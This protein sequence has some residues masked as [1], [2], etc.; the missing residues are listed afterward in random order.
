[1]ATTQSTFSGASRSARVGLRATREQEALLR[2]AAH[3]T[4]KSLAE[5]ILESA[6]RAAEQTLLEQRLF[7][8]SGR[9]Q[10][11]LLELVDRPARDNAGLRELFSKRAPWDSRKASALPV[12]SVLV[13]VVVAIGKRQR[14]AVYKAAAKLY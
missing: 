11:A 13:V 10:R 9:R 8:V 6:C 5:F 1:M 3:A 14:N 2:R 4:R 7:V 12:T